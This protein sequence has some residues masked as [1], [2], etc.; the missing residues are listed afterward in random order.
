MA[1]KEGSMAPEE[2]VET[3][4]VFT[5]APPE[6]RALLA[7]GRQA[8]R[9]AAMRAVG[10]QVAPHQMAELAVAAGAHFSRSFATV[11]EYAANTGGGG[12]TSPPAKPVTA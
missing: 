6:L 9:E 1:D 12:F 11:I 10:D 4:F 7:Q 3:F 2:I 5:K 8:F